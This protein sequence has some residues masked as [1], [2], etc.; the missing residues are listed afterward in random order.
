MKTVSFYTLGCKLNQSET[1]SLEEDFRRHGYY[2]VPFGTPSDVCVIN[3]CTVTARSDY[4]CRQSIRRAIKTAPD[5]IV[6]VVGCYAQTDVETIQTIPGVDIVLGSDRK[7]DLLNY[8]ENGNFTCE[9]GENITFRESTPG[10]AEN[11]T[12]AFLKIQDGCDSFCSYCI[13]PYARGR[14]R[15]AS[16]D[17]LLNR[18]N[19]VVEKGY[20]EV[21]LTGV[22]IG[23]YGRDLQPALSLLQLLTLL[24]ERTEVERIRLSSLEPQELSDELIELIQSSPRICN[25]FHIPLQSGSN[26]ILRAMKRHYTR[27]RFATLIEKI[28]ARIPDAG[29]GTDVIVG[30]P[31][32]SDDDF[33]ASYDLI[34]ELPFSYLHVFNYSARQGTAAES[35]PD[36][37]DDDVKKQRSHQLIK[38]G[39]SKKQQFMLSQL[40]K[41]RAVLF[42]GSMA[43][44]SGCM[45]SR[46]TIFA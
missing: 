34:T 10:L 35:L 42:E 30:F 39:Q 45:D 41:T 38:L 36:K 26:P 1:A 17:Y 16:P 24:L 18:M 25:H 28:I 21:V 12:R 43:A 32:E 15:S 46:I 7:F 27:D 29:I 44:Q 31:G 20:Q 9:Q 5:A 14:S 22:H 6:A 4:R 2:I 33:Q 13:V 19:E 37:V 11:R 23:K 40:N 3:T 8:L